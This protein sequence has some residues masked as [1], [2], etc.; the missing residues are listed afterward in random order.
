[1]GDT[2]E[3]SDLDF[4]YEDADVCL[5]EVAG[6]KTICEKINSEHKKVNSGSCFSK[7]YICFC[8]TL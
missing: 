2:L 7:N 3:G 1:M 4:T 8:M 5:M 6:K